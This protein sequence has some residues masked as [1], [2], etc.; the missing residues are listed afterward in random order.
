MLVQVVDMFFS[1]TFCPQEFLKIKGMHCIISLVAH[2]IGSD[3]LVIQTH[4]RTRADDIIS[5]ILAE[6]LEAGGAVGK[7]LQFIEENERITRHETESWVQ[8]GE[9]F[10][11]RICRVTLRK[12]LFK[13]GVRDKINFYKR[14]IFSSEL[15]DRKCFTNLPCPSHNQGFVLRK[16]FPLLQIAVDL[17]FHSELHI[18]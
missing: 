4:H 18:L 9:L 7:L 1:I 8:E 13:F 17:A 12:S 11:D 5:S 3:V 15:S 2:T 14:G 6:K 16:L 10:G